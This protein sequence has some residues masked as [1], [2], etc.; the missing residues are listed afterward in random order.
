MSP[1]VGSTVSTG[2]ILFTDMVDSTALRSRLGDDRADLLR[3]HHDALLA[4]IVEAHGGAVTRFTGDGIKAAFGSASDAVGAAVAIQRAVI[5][6]G[7]STDAIAVFQ[8]RVGLAVGEV[9]I[10][11]NGDRR[12]V[13]VV[14]AARLEALARPG[15]ILATE[16]VRMLGQRRTNV[17]FEEVGERTLKGLDDPVVVYRVI[18]LEQGAAPP[19]PRLL[20]ADQ[21][22]PIV[23][24]EQQMSAFVSQWSNAKAGVAGLLLVRGP[25]GMGKTRFVSH[26]AEIAHEG[27]AI[28]LGGMC[29][30]DLEVPTSRWP[31]RS[32]PQPAST[33]PSTQQWPHAR[34]RWPACSRAVRPAMATS[35]P[36]SLASNCST[37]SQPSCAACRA[38][39]R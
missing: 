22:L 25:A 34:A 39:T 27:G 21:R 20:V 37:P 19:M 35:S 16:M 33:R 31:W 15:E 12:G 10:D 3:T 4:G 7:T 23:G 8:I 14:E 11:E 28:V 9:T 1:V 24:R 18:D 29:S 32:G 13:A 17:M 2:A 36:H 26:C 5:E 30:S 6:Y 38:P